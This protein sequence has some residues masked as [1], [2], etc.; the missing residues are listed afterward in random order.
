MTKIRYF[1]LHPVTLKAQRVR[2]FQKKEIL[3]M[4]DFQAFAAH[5]VEICIFLGYEAV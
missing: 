1:N 4:R 5:V 2:L 3:I